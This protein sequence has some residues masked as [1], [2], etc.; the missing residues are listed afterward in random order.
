MKRTSE[1]PAGKL[2][3]DTHIWSWFV[4]GN[5]QKLSPKIIFEIEEGLKLGV[6]YVS[7][8][9]V[10]EIAVL[11]HKNRISLN[12]SI[13]NWIETAFSKGGFILVN[14]SPEIVIESY[15]LPAEFHGDPGDRML[16]GT[17]RSQDLTLL[18]RDD[19]IL[20]YSKQGYVKTK[21]G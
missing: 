3:L 17:A 10:W 4:D 15:A 21:K 5:K 9:S 18:T 1:K 2:L 6:V 11:V 13:S 8:I 7:I 12:T 20:E 16:V 14:L 19:K